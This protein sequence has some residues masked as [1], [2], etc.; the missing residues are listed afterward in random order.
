MKNKI[1]IV[2]DDE[3]IVKLLR[4]KLQE[5]FLVT[6][7]MNFRA[8][9]AEI[10]EYQPD[11]VLMDITLPYFNGFIGQLKFEKPMICRLF[12]SHRHLMR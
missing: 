1:F 7:V 12:S 6:S 11:L 3:T 5:E 4:E 9:A 8:V 2:E 10:S